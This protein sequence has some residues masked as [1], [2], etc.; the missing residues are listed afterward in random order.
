MTTPATS[1]DGIDLRGQG[2][3][4]NKIHLPNFINMKITFT[5]RIL[6]VSRTTTRSTI[7]S[8]WFVVQVNN[9]EQTLV[10]T[11]GTGDTVKVVVGT[12]DIVSRFVFF[13]FV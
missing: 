8:Y 11:D 6:E 2:K 10:L 1:E 9:D 3:R 13:L 4:V 7:C 5:G 12:E